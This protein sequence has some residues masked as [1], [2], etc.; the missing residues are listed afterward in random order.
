M[1]EN[2]IILKATDGSIFNSDDLKID[3]SPM[4]GEVDGYYKNKSDEVGFTLINGLTELAVNAI[5]FE[6]EDSAERGDAFFDFN[7]WLD[8]NEDNISDFETW[9]DN[10]NYGE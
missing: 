7:E 1:Y 4:T 8:G 2:N 5:K 10:D 9:F 6:L 3:F